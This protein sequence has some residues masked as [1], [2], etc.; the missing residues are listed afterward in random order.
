MKTFTLYIN[1][2]HFYLFSV[3]FKLEVSAAIWDV[4]IPVVSPTVT[5]KTC[6]SDTWR[7][8]TEFGTV[9]GI[10]HSVNFGKL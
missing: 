2:I 8:P 7:S 4:T 9:S 6:G 3:L 10:S 1:S 5:L